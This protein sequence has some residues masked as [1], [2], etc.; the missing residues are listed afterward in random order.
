LKLTRDWGLR[1]RS[2]KYIT[3]N[4]L[5]KLLRNSFYVGVIR[6][7]ATGQTFQGAHL[8]IV[9]KALYDRV[10]SVLTGKTNKRSIRHDFL[11][12]RRLTCKACRHTLIG[13]THKGFVYYRCQRRDC[14]MTSIRE[15]AAESAMLSTFLEL[16]FQ[17]D[18]R[19]YCTKMLDDLRARNNE[20]ID[21]AVTALRLRLSQMDERLNRLTDGYIDRL[22][23]RDL[24]EQRKNALLMERAS[25]A[26]SLTSW[27]AGKRNVA[28]E[29]SQV[30]ERADSAYLAYK[31]ADLPDKRELVDVV[32]SNRL[33]DGKALEVT[34]TSPFDLIANRF[35]SQDGSP[36][37]DIHRTWK[38]L[39][40]KLAPVFN[41]PKQLVA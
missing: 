19:R 38:C 22:I 39:L 34:L 40:A 8:P 16:Q 21:M 2:G 25:I 31:R 26:E 10:Q 1:G 29:L 30:L 6:I 36:R 13:E 11:F 20:E 23:D 24:F 12:R 35:I 27:E 15:E 32:T 14:P 37:R 18:E 17:P 9:P 4:G 3:K 28:D 41:E 7:G 33:F 5:T